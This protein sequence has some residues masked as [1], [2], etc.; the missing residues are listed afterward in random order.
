MS[1]KKEVEGLLLADLWE[2][3]YRAHSWVSFSP[4]KSAAQNWKWYTEKNRELEALQAAEKITLSSYETQS[5]L[6]RVQHAENLIMQLPQEH[7]GRNTWLLNY[8][9]KKE[10]KEKREA[11]NLNFI[12][13]TQSCETIKK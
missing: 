13:A 8:G 6:N 2:L 12:E 5:G 4:E 9:V 1:T 11:K 3:C 7:D 10:A